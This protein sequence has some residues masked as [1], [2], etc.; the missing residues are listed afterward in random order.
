MTICDMFMIRT[1]LVGDVGSS[2]VNQ[3]MNNVH[4]VESSCMISEVCIPAIE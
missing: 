3:R 2:Y 1:V 4:E